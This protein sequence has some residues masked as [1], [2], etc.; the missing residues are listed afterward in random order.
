MPGKFCP[1]CSSLTLWSQRTNSCALN[2]DIP[3]TFPLTRERAERERAARLVED[4]LGLTDDAIHVVRMNKEAVQ[5][6]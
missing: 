1:K 6:C 3:S 4:T 5:K 2:V